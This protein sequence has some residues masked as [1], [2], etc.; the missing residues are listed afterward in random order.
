MST[1]LSGE[2]PGHP[3]WVP[4]AALAAF[5]VDTPVLGAQDAGSDRACSPTHPAASRASGP[6][7]V[8]VPVGARQQGVRSSIA[9]LAGLVFGAGDRVEPPAVSSR[10][11]L[12]LVG[13]D[14]GAFSF[15]RVPRTRCV[16]P[17]LAMAAGVDPNVVVAR[18]G[19]AHR[20]GHTSAAKWDSSTWRA[21]SRVPTS[22]FVTRGRRDGESAGNR[23]G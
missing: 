18:L 8:L 7:G 9:G 5:V 20:Y 19:L 2:R 17:P 11:G 10:T 21:A 12:L 23:H 3:W 14:A 22:P 6:A 13:E 4:S 15:D 16:T 1:S